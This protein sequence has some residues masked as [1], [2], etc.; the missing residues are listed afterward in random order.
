LPQPTPLGSATGSESPTGA[1][2]GGAAAAPA[3]AGRIIGLS[4]GI[5]MVIAIA[6]VV[7]HRVVY[8]GKTDDAEGDDVEARAAVLN[9]PLMAGD[10]QLLE[11]LGV[12]DSGEVEV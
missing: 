1:E 10:A 3:H 9:G 5:G 8:Q 2:A 11:S 4:V 7:V 12:A 6:I